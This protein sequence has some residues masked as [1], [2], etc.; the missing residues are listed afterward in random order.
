[1]GTRFLL[2]GLGAAFG[3]KV[4]GKCLSEHN[5]LFFGFSSHIAFFCVLGLAKKEWL[6][7]L[8]K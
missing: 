2:V 8:G 1:M 7:Y 4:L 3:L 5:M 6:L